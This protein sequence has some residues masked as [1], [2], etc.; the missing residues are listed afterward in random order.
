MNTFSEDS[1]QRDIILPDSGVFSKAFD[2]SDVAEGMDIDSISISYMKRILQKNIPLFVLLRR[3]VKKYMRMQRNIDALRIAPVQT[4]EDIS[5][6]SD[7]K[8]LT[9]AEQ[10]EGLSETRQRF[11]NTLEQVGTEQEKKKSV[12]P[13]KPE[14]KKMKYCKFCGAELKKGTERFCSKCG[15][16]LR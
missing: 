11:I 9:G 15:K 5:G 6:N 14:I 2:F 7:M 16:K 3:T 8:K 13:E 1:W 10:K 12:V 4:E